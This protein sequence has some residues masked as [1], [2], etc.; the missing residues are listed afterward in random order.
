MNARTVA[1]FFKE[2]LLRTINPDNDKAKKSMEIAG[3]RLKMAQ[4]AF[5]LKLFSYV[6]L[7]AYTAMFH[8]ARSL[9]YKDGIQEKSHYAMYLYLKEKHSHEIPVSIIELLNIHRT[10]RH[11]ALYGLDYKPSEEEAKTSIEDA[12]IFVNE[13]RK[14]KC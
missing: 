10:E 14:L 6:M 3:E 12:K 4:K 7:E 8:A 2:R 13:I 1:D 9:L 5:N 11:D